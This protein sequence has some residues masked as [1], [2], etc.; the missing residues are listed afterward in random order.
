M[1]ELSQKGFISCDKSERACPVR[2]VGAMPDRELSGRSDVFS[3][4]RHAAEWH[5]TQKKQ[6][7][8]MIRSKKTLSVVA[9]IGLLAGAATPALAVTC[10]EFTEM[11]AAEQSDL[12]SV[13]PAFGSIYD[14]SH[15]KTVDD[16]AAASDAN[17]EEAVAVVD[18]DESTGGREAQREM[19]RGADL[20]LRIM[21]DC[22]ANPEGE[23]EDIISS[24][25]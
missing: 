15:G 2:Q 14:D 10:A 12:L 18:K 7:N 5:G 4:M 3:P 17:G 13:S 16:D 23:L 8:K 1:S 25:Q 21:E 11:S 22:K 19:G 24:T 6:E 20:I 9:S